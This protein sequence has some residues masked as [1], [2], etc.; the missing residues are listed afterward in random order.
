MQNYMTDTKL[1]A[2]LRSIAAVLAVAVLP[3]AAVLASAT[4]LPAVLRA[5]VPTATEA[6]R[7]A[8]GDNHTAPTATSAPETT[9]SF[10]QPACNSFFPR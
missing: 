1:A 4:V 6:V 2:E 9:A 5:R 8:A 7:A 10:R 3:A